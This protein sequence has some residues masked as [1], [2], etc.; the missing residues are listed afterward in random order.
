MIMINDNDIND[1]IIII[2]Y[3]IIIFNIISYQNLVNIHIISSKSI[4][5][6]IVTTTNILPTNG[7]ISAKRKKSLGSIYINGNVFLVTNKQVINQNK[8]IIG[9]MMLY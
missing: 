3:N 8:V 2:R 5:L 4:E 7:H 1:N 9:L 6:Y